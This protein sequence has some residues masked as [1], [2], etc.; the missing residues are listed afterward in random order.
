MKR[1]VTHFAAV[2]PFVLLLIPGLQAAGQAASSTESPLLQKGTMTLWEARRNL[3]ESI[4]RADP[5]HSHMIIDLKSIRFTQDSFEFDAVC[6]KK[7]EHFTVDLKNLDPVR[8]H[9]ERDGTWFRIKNE[10]GKDLPAPLSRLVFLNLIGDDSYDEFAA[11][12]NSLRILAGEAGDPLRN[13]A[14]Q[15][16]AWRALAVK[17]PLPEDAR[18]QRLMAE[19]AVKANKPAEALRF[20]ETGIELYPTWPEGNFNAALIDGEL[21]YYG[22]AIEHMQAYLTLVPDAPDAQAARDKIAVWKYQAGQ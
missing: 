14:Q 9:D 10:A 16:A 18:I 17:P 3:E 7:Q 20:Y 12:L 13:F 6:D 8:A 15:A 5:K 2:I 22:D 21:G 4:M 1:F 19:E 11:A